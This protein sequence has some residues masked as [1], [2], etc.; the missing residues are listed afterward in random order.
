MLAADHLRPDEEPADDRPEQPRRDLAGDDRRRRELPA[1]GRRDTP[2]LL[3]A[4]G[5]G[6]T[7]VIGRQA[8]TEP[9]SNQIRSP[10]NRR[11]AGSHGNRIRT[12]RLHR[13]AGRRGAGPRPEVRA[14][15]P[16]DLEDALRPHDDLGQ[17]EPVVRE[18][19][20][21]LRVERAGA[22]VARASAG[23]SAPARTRS[24]GARVAISP[25]MSRA[26]SAIEWRT[27]SF[28]IAR[29]SSGSNRRARRDRI[30]GR[31]GHAAHC[32]A[33]LR[34]RRLSGPGRAGYWSLAS[35]EDAS[36]A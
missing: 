14:G 22:V 4:P 3:R 34:G 33:V 13:Q 17:R 25:S 18:R 19:R 8:W 29:S 5:A 20:E 27:H 7:A 31:V 1:A 15:E 36:S 10:R 12:S 30:G 2:V 26:S 24:P 9:R 16:R 28:L 35:G 21:Q 23:P 11:L 6:S 32:G